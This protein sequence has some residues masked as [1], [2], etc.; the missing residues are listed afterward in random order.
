MYRTYLAALSVSTSLS[1][2]QALLPAPLSYP[3]AATSPVLRSHTH[4]PVLYFHMHLYCSVFHQSLVSFPFRCWLLLVHI[5][6]LYWSCPTRNDPL[7]YSSS[8]TVNMNIY[9]TPANSGHYAIVAL[10]F[11]TTWVLLTPRH[12]LETQD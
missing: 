3:S 11:I 5:S 10:I 6:F 4:V 7:A 1:F 2:Q 8:M 9:L 12:A